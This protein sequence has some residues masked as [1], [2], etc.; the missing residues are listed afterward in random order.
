M[1][2]FL[3]AKDLC[4]ADGPYQLALGDAAALFYLKLNIVIGFGVPSLRADPCD[5]L[6]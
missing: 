4:I 5:L 6:L 1:L 3:K 2:S